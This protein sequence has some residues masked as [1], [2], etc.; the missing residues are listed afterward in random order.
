MNNLPYINQIYKK[1]YNDIYN[2]VNIQV[3]QYAKQQKPIP[4]IKHHIKCPN[5]RAECN[6][7]LENDKIFVETECCVCLEKT[8]NPILLK[9]KHAVC[10][11]CCKE[12]ANN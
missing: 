5:C 6:V 11:G 9:C 10:A 2:F 3:Q 12:L 7:S 8:N 1:S 4:V